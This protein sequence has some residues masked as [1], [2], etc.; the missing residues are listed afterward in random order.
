[1]LK[2]PSSR[3]QTGLAPVTAGNTLQVIGDG[4]LAHAT[5]VPRWGTLGPFCGTA[6]PGFAFVRRNPWG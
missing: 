6:L 1:M 3:D 4:S 2:S 5:D